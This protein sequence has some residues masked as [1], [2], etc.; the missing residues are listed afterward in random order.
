MCACC[1]YDAMQFVSV[2]W[3]SESDG[4]SSDGAGVDVM[5]VAAVHELVKS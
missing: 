3:W 5:S 1:W 4:I 2:L